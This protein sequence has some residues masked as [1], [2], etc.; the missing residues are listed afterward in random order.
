[1]SEPA[2]T[3]VHLMRH[4]EV[5]NP[6]GVLY[7]RLPGYRLSALGH[8]MA[9]TVAR[10][11]ADHDVALV[12]ASSL[13]RAQQT[14]DPIARAH[15]VPVLTDDRVIEAGNHFEGLTFGRGA[16]SL[17][18]IQ[19]LRRLWNPVRPSWGE[20]YQRI[21]ERMLAAIEDARDHA[22]GHEAVLVSHQLPIWTIRCRLEGRRLW[23][24]P[25]NRE[26]TL[27]SLTSL[28]FEGDELEAISYCE[29]AGALLARAHAT[30]G[31]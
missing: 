27:A 24:D 6:E 18:R 11:L 29:P 1:M 21:A 8:E 31:A 4:G 30:V 12:V 7:G 3:V 23:H 14:A 16:G 5:D 20:P 19:N 9:D 25:R 13:L 10:H 28:T 22:R 15:E 26:C 2:R 17:R